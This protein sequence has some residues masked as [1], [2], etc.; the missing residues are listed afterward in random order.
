MG[1]TKPWWVEAEEKMAAKRAERGDADEVKRLPKRTS[2][3]DV[4]ARASALGVSIDGTKDEII[5]RIYEHEVALAEGSTP[6]GDDQGNG[7]D[8]YDEADREVLVAFAE[9]EPA[10]AGA[11]DM[12]DDTLKAAIRERDARLAS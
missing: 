2:K 8:A 11:A 1:K 12:D 3:D 10:I 5:E 6:P 9:Q 4:E 7:G